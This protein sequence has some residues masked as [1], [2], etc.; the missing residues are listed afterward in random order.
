MVVGA[1][2]NNYSFKK[3]SSLSYYLKL[4]IFIIAKACLATVAP[5][6]SGKGRSLWYEGRGFKS[7]S[8]FDGVLEKPRKGIELEQRPTISCDFK[9]K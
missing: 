4:T 3:V 5:W 8:M 2:R 7:R 1:I 6:P 9:I